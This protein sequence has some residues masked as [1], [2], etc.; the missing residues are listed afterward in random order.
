MPS[1]AM[2]TWAGVKEGVPP[3]LDFPD[4]FFRVS[5]GLNSFQSYSGRI[6]LKS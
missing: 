6:N 5:M 2:R 1:N 4:A 3:V